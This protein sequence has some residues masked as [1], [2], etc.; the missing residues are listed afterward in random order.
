MHSLVPH[1]DLDCTSVSLNKTDEHSVSTVFI[2]L[3]EMTTLTGETKLR[4]VG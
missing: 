3:G 1:C 4:I 2:Y